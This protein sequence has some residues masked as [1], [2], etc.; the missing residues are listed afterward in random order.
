MENFN[1]WLQLLEEG[2][3]KTKKRNREW[4]TGEKLG[5][6]GTVA[7]SLKHKDI[8]STTGEKGKLNPYAIFTA[9]AKKGMKTKYK[10]QASTLEGT[11]K[12]KK[13]FQEWLEVREERDPTKTRV[14][15]ILNNSKPFS[16][17]VR[18][19]CKED[20]PKQASEKKA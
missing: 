12:K 10:N 13:K 9:K 11:P 8:F 5:I 6:K 17:F 19:D 20:K 14:K 18:S 3:K 1:K 4:K 15:K 2:K 7:A 16:G